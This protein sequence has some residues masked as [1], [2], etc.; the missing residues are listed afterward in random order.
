MNYEQQWHDLTANFDLDLQA[1]ILA[2]TVILMIFRW[3]MLFNIIVPIF[4]NLPRLEH[5][6]CYGNL[7]R[8]QTFWLSDSICML[9]SIFSVGAFISWTKVLSVDQ[10]QFRLCLSWDTQIKSIQ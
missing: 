8:K 6:G 1:S 7:I 5:V 3:K 9:S 4:I 10:S 2:G